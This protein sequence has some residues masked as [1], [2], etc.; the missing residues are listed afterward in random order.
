[1]PKSKF[2]NVTAAVDS[3]VRLSYPQL[4]FVYTLG[5]LA[6]AAGYWVLYTYAPSHGPTLPAGEPWE[7]ALNAIYFSLVTALSIGYGDIVPLG[8]SK[9]LAMAEAMGALFVFGILVSKPISY[10]QELALSQVH[11]LTFNDALISIREGLFVVRRDMQAIAEHAAEH[12]K[13]TKKDWKNLI[14]AYRHYCVLLENMQEFY[15]EDTT[16]IYEM[17]AK[18]ELLLLDATQRTLDRIAETL[19]VLQAANISHKEFQE[20]DAE[21]QWVQ[22]GN[23]ELLSRLERKSPHK[24]RAKLEK[25]RKT[26]ENIRSL[27]A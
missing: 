19:S 22:Q 6:C 27:A 20:A 4:F 9:I 25:L 11:S 1:M 24:H 2:S 8:A 17:S 15:P 12:G 3:L 14:V 7:I 10:R 21:F 18:R 23:V 16:G 26:A 5:I 13:L